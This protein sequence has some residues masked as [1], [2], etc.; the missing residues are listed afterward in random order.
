MRIELDKGSY[1]TGNYATVGGGKDWVE[2]DN[3]PI[4]AD[5]ADYCNKIICYQYIDNQ[6]VFDAE[7][8]NKL[9]EEKIKIMK[10]SE[11]TAQIISLKEELSETDYQVIKC[12]EC[13]ALNYEMPYDIE[14]LHRSRQVLRDKINELETKITE[15]EVKE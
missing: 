6:F 10:K 15:L 7:K 11:L 12:A 2:V 1:L 8:C 13:T 4:F 14:A 5:D 3:F 9:K